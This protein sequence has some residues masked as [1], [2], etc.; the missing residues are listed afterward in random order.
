MKE[1][2]AAGEGEGKEERGGCGGERGGGDKWR[3]GC[4]CPL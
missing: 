2:E 1:E 4:I 3:N